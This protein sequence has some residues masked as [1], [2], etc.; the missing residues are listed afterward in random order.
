MKT[1]FRFVLVCFLTFTTQI[2]GIVYLLSLVISKKWN[3]KLKFKT[4]IIFIG[5]Y[6]LSTLIIIPLIAPFFGR[7]KVK[8]SEK[9][10]PTNYMTVLLNRNYVKP[11][12]NDLLS[13]T[14]KKLNGSNITIHYLDANFPFINKFPLL[15]HMS[16]NDGKKI[17]ISLVYETQNG[18]ITNKQKSV[19][20]Y[21]VFEAPKSN[22]Y[23]QI[24][25]CLKENLLYDFPKYLTFGKINK[26]LVFSEKGTKMLI[27]NI[28]NSSDV[29]KIFIEPHL[30]NRINLKNKKIRFHG[31]G[32]VRHDDHIHI[33]L[34]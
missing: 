5:L 9:I 1:L 11:K 34:K 20:G 24:N 31:C 26:E 19:S 28:L 18:I 16:H 14:A 6:F 32:A 3:K 33:E 4:S 23:D 2:G 10:K 22:E 30:K 13:N 21:G 12:L 25:K 15:P 7:E 8:N 27:K 29:G 17:D